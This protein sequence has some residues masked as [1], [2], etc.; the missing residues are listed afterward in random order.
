[1]DELEVAEESVKCLGTNT[2]LTKDLSKKYAID[3]AA[4]TNVYTSAKGLKM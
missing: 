3:S 1:V 4:T 2:N